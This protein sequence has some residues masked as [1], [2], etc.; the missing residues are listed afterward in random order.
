MALPD[1]D[2]CLYFVSYSGVKLPLK[3]VNQLE[4]EE[5]ENR[6]T[7]FCGYY[8]QKGLMVACE[9]RVY[10]EVEYQ[11]RYQY[12]PSGKIKSALIA[13]AGGEPQQI[14]FPER[15]SATGNKP[16]GY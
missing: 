3:L 2:H 16:G 11:H 14:D 6:N 4:E 13:M 7:Y 12:Y 5:T 1:F 15:S 10:G 8:D 9:K